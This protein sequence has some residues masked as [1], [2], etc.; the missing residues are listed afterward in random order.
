MG[1]LFVSGDH[2]FGHEN[3]I[4]YC[5]RPFKS[6]THMNQELVRRWNER[7]KEGD[8][9]LYLGDFCFP[10]PEYGVE[11]YTDQLNGEIIFIKGS[12]DS[13]INSHIVSCIVNYHGIDWWC[14]H[15]PPKKHRFTYNLCAHVHEKWKLKRSGTHII[16][17]IGVDQW[18]FYPVSFPEI[19]KFLK[20]EGIKI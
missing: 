17:N 11:Y 3:I 9:V 1:N 12:H 20:S 5:K 16:L 8:T 7:V 18:E 2:H 19:I 13:K 15:E 6:I 10:H 4:K 14:Q